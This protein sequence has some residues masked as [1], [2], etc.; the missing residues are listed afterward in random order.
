MQSIDAEII[1]MACYYK[2]DSTRCIILSARKFL[3]PILM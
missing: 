1:N 3:Q 2:P